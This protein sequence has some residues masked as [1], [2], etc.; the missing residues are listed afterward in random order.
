MQLDYSLNQLLK[1][2]TIISLYAA[3]IGTGGYVAGLFGMN[4]N[5]TTTIQNIPYIFE[6]VCYSSALGA[7]VGFFL[8]IKYLTATGVLPKTRKY[9]RKR[10][11]ESSWPCL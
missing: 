10:K 4:L 6:V 5:N 9:N 8:L 11:H 7:L 2:N 3:A 1:L